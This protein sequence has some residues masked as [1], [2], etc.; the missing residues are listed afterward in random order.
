M[1]TVKTS[2]VASFRYDLLDWFRHAQRDLPWRYHRDPYRVWISEVMLQQT[3]VDQAIPYFNRFIDLY[4]DVRSLA[5]ASIDDV[6]SAWEG[7]GYYS[8]AHNLHKTAKI[9]SEEREGY[10]PNTYSELLSLPGIGPYTAA[11]VASIAFE[12]RHAVVD[13]NVIRVLSR[14]FRIEHESKSGVMRRTAQ[15][16]GDELVPPEAPGIFNEAIMEL[17]ATVCTPASPRC[18]ACPLRP[19]C[20]AYVE[21]KQ[22]AYPR[23]SPRKALP[24][25]HIAVGLIIDEERIL[26]QRRP[27]DGMLG[28]LWEFPG[29]KQEPGESLE[30]TCRREVQEEAGLNVRVEN[31]L[32][33]IRHAYSHFRITLHAYI[34]SVTDGELIDDTLYPKVWARLD[35]LDEIA[36]P[37]ANRR[38]IEKLQLSHT[39]IT[40]QSR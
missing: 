22:T 30:E 8:R 12:Q 29:G 5:A 2:H 21:G 38:I 37:R 10:F 11:A 36:F 3:R 19:V 15:R 1:P 6:L 17:G 31:K 24:H 26:I 25:H 18:T 23:P 4:P 14:V 28:G 39:D 34:C 9:V 40:S 27:E 20:E 32:C 16:L 13:G 7:L 33:A 35:E